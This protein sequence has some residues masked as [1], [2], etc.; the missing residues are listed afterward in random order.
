MIELQKFVEIQEQ[1]LLPVLKFKVSSPA[2]EQRCLQQ[3]EKQ[4]IFPI[5]FEV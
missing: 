4:H 1:F 3:Q 2:R 5:H